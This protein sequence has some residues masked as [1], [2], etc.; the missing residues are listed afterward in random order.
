MPDWLP[1][2]VNGGRAFVVIGAV[3]LFWILTEWPSG[4]T[5]ISFAAIIVTLLAPR[6]DQAYAGGIAFLLGTLLNVVI[7]ATIAFAVLPGSGAETF[8]AF[9]LVIGLCLVPIGA[10][11]MHAR[12]PLQVGI[13][14]GMTMTFMPLAFVWYRSARC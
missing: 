6:A 12:Q 2:L 14:T 9:S 1:A 8:G 3:A 4:A 10:L 11:L 7:T 13:F 5:A